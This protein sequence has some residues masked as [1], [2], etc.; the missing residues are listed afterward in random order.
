LRVLDIQQG[1]Q[2]VDLHFRVSSARRGYS[3]TGMACRS[4][5]DPAS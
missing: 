1:N 3:R 4:V 2:A 5:P